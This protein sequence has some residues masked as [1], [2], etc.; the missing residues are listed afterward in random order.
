[1]IVSQKKDSSYAL[2]L[3]Q[4][5][6]RISRLT[7]ESGQ[8]AGTTQLLCRSQPQAMVRH[9][10][11]IVALLR[12]R[13]RGYHVLQLTVCTWRTPS[14]S[15]Q[16]AQQ[17]IDI[18]NFIVIIEEMRSRGFIGQHE[19]MVMLAVLRLGREAYGVP[20]ATEIADRTGRE[21]LLGSVYAILDRLEAKGLVSSRIGDATPE[22]GGRAKRYFNLTAQGVRHVRE[23]QRALEVW[24]D[25]PRASGTKP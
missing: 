24:V 18:L 17:F 23:A 2:L 7:P 9:R 16:A 6:N 15:R 19:L 13:I 3:S 11:G 5:G 10:F 25:L 21:M 12:G 20:I 14:T 4:C 8:S 1:M 22:R